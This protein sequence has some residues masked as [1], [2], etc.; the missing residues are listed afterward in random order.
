MDIRIFRQR[1][2]LK[3]KLMTIKCFEQGNN[4]GKSFNDSQEKMR[5]NVKEYF[6]FKCMPYY[7]NPIFAFDR[8]TYLVIVEIDESCKHEHVDISQT[9]DIPI[10]LIRYNPGEY[11]KKI[12]NMRIQ[13]ESYGERMETLHR[14]IVK[15]SLTSSDNYREVVELFF[16]GYDQETTILESKEV[17][18]GSSNCENESS[19][20]CLK[21]VPIIQWLI[22][23]VRKF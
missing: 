21:D 13:H 23:H 19:F 17:I 10:V 16:D 11:S 5:C 9:L 7:N 12:G 18:V 3:D 15:C 8:G 22:C 4:K 6:D 14:W 1:S 2:L 20:I